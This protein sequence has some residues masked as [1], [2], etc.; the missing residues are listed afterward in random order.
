MSSTGPSGLRE[1]FQTLRR[2]KWLVLFVV[3]AI[4]AVAVALSS[5]QSPS[6]RASSQVLLNSQDVSAALSQANNSNAS[7]DPGRYATTQSRLA[8]VTV[9]AQAAVDKAGL[10]VTAKQ[11]LDNSS[12]TASPDSDLLEFDVDNGTAIG[13]QRLANS[14]AAAFVKFRRF[15]DTRALKRAHD[16]V[17][18]RLRTL[19]ESGD[20]QSALYR[21]L[22]ATEEQLSALQAVQTSHAIVV[23]TARS[24]TQ[25]QPK[26][27]RNG[28]LALVLALILGVGLAF[29]VQALDTR[30]RDAVEIAD[31]LGLP[32]LA[33]IP[34][35]ARRFG[36]RNEMV[37]LAEPGSA[38]AEA[39]R[40]LR[41]SLELSNLDRSARSVM[42]SSAVQEVGKSTTIANLAVATARAGKR[43]ILIDLDLRRGDLDRLFGVEDEPGV[44]DVALG[45]LSIDDA[46]QPIE[47]EPDGGQQPLGDLYI[48]PAGHLPPSAG[49]LV[50]S[51]RVGEILADL[52]ER[53]DVLFIDAPPFLQVGDAIALSARVDGL[54]VVA[55]LDVRR[56][57]IEE[58]RRVL[59][60]FRTY[61]LGVVVTG[62][63]SDA[64]YGGYEATRSSRR[65]V[66]E[67]VG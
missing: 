14:Y 67:P 11:L 28:V 43:V 42:I 55:P 24:A 52:T 16:D 1:Y 9:V 53:A 22:A 18:A 57:V 47:L 39:F 12:V 32:L 65:E 63:R 35:P 15:L 34:K 29:L 40:L 25:T 31:A 56:P 54:V 60:Q 20:K 3:V 48:L 33:R 41:T 8:T 2:R 66:H 17:A 6:Y 21:S 23:R 19:A 61:P 50:A 59:E 36:K 30:M 4:P 7:Q 62:G 64:S 10:P 49:E 13:A 58:M 38:D 51:T 5:R 26:T 45:G 37:M 27:V 44:S 46:L